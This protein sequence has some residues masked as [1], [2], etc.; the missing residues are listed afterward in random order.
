MDLME[1][2]DEYIG[3]TIVE[4]WA[5]EGLVSLVPPVEELYFNISACI[6]CQ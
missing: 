2:G 3:G 1:R 5:I 6:D 4:P